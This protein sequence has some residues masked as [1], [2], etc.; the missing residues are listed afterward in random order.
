LAKI[1]ELKIQS[2]KKSKGS[3]EINDFC[4]QLFFFRV[5]LELGTEEAFI[6]L[7]ESFSVMEIIDGLKNNSGT[8]MIT[9]VIWP[10]NEATLN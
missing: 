1:F 10:S 8:L 3:F 6:Q 2:L 9:F 4:Q 5:L 7:K